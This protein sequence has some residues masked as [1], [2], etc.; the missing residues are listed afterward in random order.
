MKIAESDR[1]SVQT[2]SIAN[3]LQGVSGKGM[4]A[5]PVLQRR[6]DPAEGPLTDEAIA[7]PTTRQAQPFPAPALPQ[8]SPENRPGIQKPFVPVQRKENNTGLPDHLKAGVEGLSGVSMDEVKVHYN[9]AKPA[10][11][12]A[13]AYAQGHDIH[14]APGQEKHLPHE[15]W[16][17]VQQKQGRV[18]ATMQ[19]K[20]EGLN[21]D[22]GLEKEADVM[23]EKAAGFQG[24]GLRAEKNQGGSLSPAP[25]QRVIK[26]QSDADKIKADLA[27]YCEGKK[28]LKGATGGAA[29]EVYLSTATAALAEECFVGEGDDVVVKKVVVRS[30]GDIRTGEAGDSAIPL[31][32][33]LPG[34]L[35]GGDLVDAANDTF[36]TLQV[37]DDDVIK[38][39][40]LV[41]AYAEGGDQAHHKVKK[42]ELAEFNVKAK[43]YYTKL[44]KIFTRLAA[45]GYSSGD[46]KP[47][48]IF[49]DDAGLPMLGD[50][51]DYTRG[52]YT[53]KAT[54]ITAL[55][56]DLM[57]SSGQ[58]KTYEQIVAWAA[59]DAQWMVAEA[60]AI[61]EVLPVE[62]AVE[63]AVVIGGDQV[64]GE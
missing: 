64:V 10:Q 33:L 58:A 19:M 54:D 8:S 37:M 53:G 28:S 17:V 7:M 26:V 45:S 3:T 36:V 6:E 44:D 30:M 49:L 46:I 61:P 57:K 1:A 60:V 27:K 18:Q 38:S 51:G 12:Q 31:E 24:P 11:L 29:G 23:G 55:M 40:Y 63:Q 41:M 32:A 43:A 48:N 9:S 13:F 14:I 62:E 42:P 25:V 50:F 47:A 35:N 4:P 22:A 59:G 20:G 5:I 39:Y 2:V 21:D 52:S 15:A 56:N 16:H 34:K